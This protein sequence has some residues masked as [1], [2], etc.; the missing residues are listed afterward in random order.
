[1]SS[2]TGVGKEGNVSSLEKLNFLQEGIIKKSLG[3]EIDL[4]GRMN[5]FLK[6]KSRYL[7]RVSDGALTKQE[8]RSPFHTEVVSSAITEAGWQNLRMM[9]DDD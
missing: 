2:A 1:V 4:A 9:N 6:Q 7:P 5:A 3:D 8:A